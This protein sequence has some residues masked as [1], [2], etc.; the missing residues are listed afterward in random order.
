MA[1]RRGL[2]LLSAELGA[3]DTWAL[4]SRQAE[5]TAGGWDI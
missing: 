5:A 1:D 3:L 4:S 2:H